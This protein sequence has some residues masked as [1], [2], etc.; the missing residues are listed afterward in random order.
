MYMF[1]KEKFLTMITACCI[2]QL[3]AFCKYYIA[4]FCTLEIKSHNSTKRRGKWRNLSGTSTFLISDSSVADF[5]GCIQLWTQIDKHTYQH[6]Y[7]S[8]YVVTMSKYWFYVFHIRQYNKIIINQY[9]MMYKSVKMMI[10]HLVKENKQ[11]QV[12]K[13]VSLNQGLSWFERPTIAGT[14]SN[15]D[16]WHW[17][18]VGLKFICLKQVVIQMFVSSLSFRPFKVNSGDNI[19]SKHCKLIGSWSRKLVSIKPT[20]RSFSSFL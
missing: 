14:C 17:K 5:F 15:M 3:I 11:P 8:C 4:H 10:V 20:D 12:T 9:L 6:H 13:M 1:T 19:F 2:L 16:T 18:L 7:N